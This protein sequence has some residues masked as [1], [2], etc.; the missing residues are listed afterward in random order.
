MPTAD[1][2]QKALSQLEYLQRPPR[3]QYHWARLKYNNILQNFKTIMEGKSEEG[4]K[5]LKALKSDLTQEK[6]DA[7][8][9]NTLTVQAQ[10]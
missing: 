8:P 1:D 3:T 10:S 4:A 9:I 2:S 5:R 6:I 7:M